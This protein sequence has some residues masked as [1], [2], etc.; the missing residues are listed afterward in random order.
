VGLELRD[1]HEPPYLGEWCTL[2]EVIAEVAA[3][4]EILPKAH[5]ESESKSLKL[6]TPEGADVRL[7]QS[8]RIAR[9]LNAGGVASLS[10]VDGGHDSILLAHGGRG[11]LG[12]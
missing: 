1:I 3:W 11:D 12:F 4:R 9:C 7:D 2:E 5:L 6:E 10:T 8:N